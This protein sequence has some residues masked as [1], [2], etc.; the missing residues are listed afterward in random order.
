MFIQARCLYVIGSERQN[1]QRIYSS[2]NSLGLISKIFARSDDNIDDILE[3]LQLL[4]DQTVFSKKVSKVDRENTG[5]YIS[6]PFFSSHVKMPIKCGEYVWIY[7]YESND[8]LYS[9]FSTNSYWVSRVHGLDHSEDA[10]FTFND[11]DIDV[12]FAS[13][14]LS[15][16]FKNEEEV[17]ARK[18]KVLKNYKLDQENN[19][20]KP[21]IGFGNSTFELDNQE[22]QFLKNN[23]SIYPNNCVPKISNNPEDL[24]LQGSNNTFIKMS[25]DRTSDGSYSNNSSGKGEISIVSGPGKQ[26]SGYNYSNSGLFINQKGMKY[27]DSS[28]R[29]QVS[30]GNL[31]NKLIHEKE[32]FEENIKNV[33]LYSLKEVEKNSLEGAFSV[34]DDSSKIIVS[35]YA[36][37]ESIL[38]SNFDIFLN[39]GSFSN[40][41]STFELESNLLKEGEE[42]KKFNLNNFSNNYDYISSFDFPTISL[43]SDGINTFSRMGAGCISLTKEY[44]SSDLDRQLNACVRLDK[45]GDIY[46]DGNRIFIGSESLEK[47]KGTFKNGQGTIVNIGLGEESQSLVLGEQLKEYMKEMISI[48][49]EDMDLT[50]KLFEHVRDTQTDMDTNTFSEIEFALNNTV[51]NITAGLVEI[52]PLAAQ[53]AP[54][55]PKILNIINTLTTD[56]LNAITTA[57][58]NNTDRL[59][60]LSEEISLAKLKKEEELSNRIKTISDNIDKILS[61]I[62]K[63]S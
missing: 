39:I 17:K 29:L 43:I 35:E 14:N 38:N 44:Y 8:S 62:S 57:N 9:N 41:K 42:E 26:S 24:F 50:K 18:K 63:T 40:S 60:K 58:K 61:K 12:K 37:Y 49:I 23:L 22:I 3:F 21:E 20:V 34:L 52:P 51:N 59:N 30:N 31:P 55:I 6:L 11:R 32:N 48:N 45:D 46:I 25:T 10:N 13:N 2:L 5:Y 36:N 54:A 15:R 16:D 4:P 33:S 47:E 28:Y 53:A 27:L 1:G 56:L 7:P 19:I